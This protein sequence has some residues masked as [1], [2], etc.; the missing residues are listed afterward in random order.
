MMHQTK[1]AALAEVEGI[2]SDNYHDWE[3][4]TLNPLKGTWSKSALHYA[5]HEPH[6][7][8]AGTRKR[9]K[10]V[11]FM[12]SLVDC[13]MTE[14]EKFNDLYIVTEEEDGRKKAH[15]D[16]KK[17]AEDQGK[18]L[19]K[20]S[21]LKLAEDMIEKVLGH[22]E[23]AAMAKAEPQRVFTAALKLHHPA[24]NETGYVA[25]KLKT[26]YTEDHGDGS[27]TVW[28][29]KVT[30]H[31]TDDDI[32]KISRRLGY[33]WQEELYSGAIQA[34]GYHVRS[35]KFVFVC[36]VFPHR[37][38]IVEF[39]NEALSGASRGIRKAFSIVKAVADGHVPA[40]FETKTLVLGSKPEQLPYWDTVQPIPTEMQVDVEW[41]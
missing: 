4:N 3:P 16:A 14:P 33:H 29:L 36:D 9:F 22:P 37:V 32:A 6:K 34:N 26:D 28:D 40:E 25:F 20:A 19:V 17:L 13:L 27:M 18:S 1:A 30:G 12:G 38:R 11:M 23:G 24:K 39:N 5:A 15:Q 31:E 2:N 35:F 8:A 7:W 21:E 10:S 41:A